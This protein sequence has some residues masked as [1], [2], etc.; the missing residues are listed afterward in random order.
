MGDKQRGQGVAASQGRLPGEQTQRVGS[1]LTVS[2][3][4]GL[5]VGRFSGRFWAGQSQLNA[6]SQYSI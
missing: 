6:V 5:V 1:A 2:E 4:Q 3:L